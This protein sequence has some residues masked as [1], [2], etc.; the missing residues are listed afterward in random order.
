M[1]K[2]EKTTVREMAFSY[3]QKYGFQD[4]KQILHFWRGDFYFWDGVYRA[5]DKAEMKAR[6]V[7]HL[8]E[9]GQIATTNLIEN[10][11]LNL[12]AQCFLPFDREPNTWLRPGEGKEQVSAIVTE[13][14]ILLF[15][16]KGGVSVVDNTPE[17]FCLNK[18][19]YK[20]D[21][22]AT[23]ERWLQ[24]IDEVTLG[25]K[26]LQ[27]MLQQW[28]GYLLLP[29][30]KYQIFLLLL[31]EAATG[32][33]TYTRAMEAMLGR[34][35]CSGVPLRRFTNNF[36][37]YQTYGKKLNVVGDAE[38]ELTP[39]VEAVIK[40]W[41]GMDGLDYERKYADGFSAQA[42]A[43]LMISA[44]SRPT[45]TDKSMGTWRRLKLVPF[46]RENMEYM[47]PA[48]DERIEAEMPGV[49]NW[50]IE[51]LK[52]LEATGVFFV[53]QKCKQIWMEYKEESNPAAMFISENYEYDPT[54]G[55]G[56]ETSVIYQSYRKWCKDKGYQ[57]MSDRTFG[58]ELFRI[59]HNTKKRRLGDKTRYQIYQGIRLRLDAE[60]R[61]RR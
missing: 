16:K 11:K 57:P 27:R 40:T 39:Q 38:E 43:K 45:F 1:P 7:L 58:K 22:G 41:T 33:G 12:S 26:E 36:S 60:I 42:T 61:G 49:L 10:V 29:T 52:D 46:R 9:I 8:G 32:K 17:F 15:D 44:N 34:E 59:F 50:A 24:F 48:L 53:A 51:G 3:L 23:C 2:E 18:V 55:F 19:P 13:G 54:W 28:A 30:Q 14:G 25:E 35:N 5:I 56:V 37:L 21:P 6:L 4:G 47:E 20:Y 31:G